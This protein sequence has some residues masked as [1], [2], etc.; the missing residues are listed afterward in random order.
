MATKRRNGEGM[1]RQRK[2]GL[3]EARITL[4]DGKKKS[5]YGSTYAAVRKWLTEAVRNRDQGLSVVLDERQTLAQYLADWLKT[6]RTR[7]RPRSYTRY[8][9]AVRLHVLPMLGR[10]PL[11]RLQPQ[12][13]QALYRDKLAEGQSAGSVARLHAVLHKAL[14]D[15][16]RLGLVARNVASLV[17]APSARASAAQQKSTS[18][19]PEQ[20]S[21]LL[22]AI[23]KHPLEA[24]FTLALTTGMRRGEL[25][26]LRWV[27]IDLE[28]GRAD[29]HQTVEHMRG[30]EYVFAAP[31][32][33]RSRRN[34]A[35]GS[36]GVAALRR[37]RARQNEQRLAVGAA[38]VDED[39]IFTD[40][41]GRPLR[42]NHILQRQFHPLLRAA[43]LPMIRLHDLRH[44]TAT[45]AAEEGAP[46]GNVSDL[47]GHSSA[48]MT[49]DMYRHK[50][51][52]S[53]DIAVAAVERAILR[54]RGTT[55]RDTQ[56][57]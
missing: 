5:H 40:A 22:A 24:F 44:T 17:Q 42:G 34:A 18:L 56:A 50:F 35:L 9:E 20:A 57:E 3:W 25:L 55:E 8:E 13:V 49:L 31:K 37:H 26:G 23:A 27:D 36:F 30:G 48:A 6:M 54:T 29:V 47:L 11:A 4:P 1:I 2:D 12:Q 51:D 21:Q 14:A 41:I 33:Q 19:T 32:T 43:G 15:A 39:L 10:V 52:T 46:V 45:L 16:L 38:W 53:A 28:K 7:L